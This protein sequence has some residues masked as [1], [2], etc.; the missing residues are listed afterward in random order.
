MIER[1]G[2]AYASEDSSLINSGVRHSTV[3]ARWADPHP[4][5]PSGRWISS[6]HL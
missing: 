1:F 4:L 5:R 3:T 2:I 6:R